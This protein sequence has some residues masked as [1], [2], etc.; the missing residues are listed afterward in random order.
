MP[1][2]PPLYARRP[3]HV[4]VWF[5]SNAAPSDLVET[6]GSH[7]IRLVQVQSDQQLAEALAAGFD[8]DVIVPFGRMADIEPFAQAAHRVLT[9]EDRDVGIIYATL[10][11]T[12]EDWAMPTDP[13]PFGSPSRHVP[14]FGQGAWRE[15]VETLRQWGSEPRLNACPGRTPVNIVPG[16]DL[17]LEEW[18]RRLLRAAFREATQ[19][20]VYRVA[21]GYSGSILMRAHAVYRDGSELPPLMAKA[22]PDLTAPAEVSHFQSTLRLKLDRS[23]FSEPETLRMVTG[24]GRS[25]SV[26]PLVAGPGGEIVTLRALFELRPDDVLPVIDR[27]AGNLKR[28][29][30]GA[31]ACD[32]SIA[33]S[34]L[35][36][37]TA[38][39]DA[40]LAQEL[41]VMRWPGISDA[42][43]RIGAF[44][45]WLDRTAGPASKNALVHGDLHCDNVV[46][47]DDGQLKPVLIDFAHTEQGH[48]VADLAALSADILFRVVPAML[49]RSRQMDS[50]RALF[51]QQQA[52]NVPDRVLARLRDHAKEHLSCGPREFCGAMLCRILWIIPRAKD[53]Q[54][55]ESLRAAADSLYRVLSGT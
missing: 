47:R 19:V 38:E 24:E 12:P 40:N 29:F 22:F 21:P 26:S 13:R 46:I 4:A 7:G 27:L 33:K 32:Y 50:A 36:R 51:D 17:E 15:T 14:R 43:D 25:M 16:G 42:A 2:S 31:Q 1:F 39:Q 18:H 10:E 11:R 8:V 6:L 30:Q 45:I 9:P 54:D 48:A 28:V 52:T 53:P 37:L 49:G 3:E 55:R 23:D 44:R 5:S 41:Q 20:S 35:A 34:Y